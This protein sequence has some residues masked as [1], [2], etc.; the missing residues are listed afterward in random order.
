M[1]KAFTEMSDEGFRWIKNPPL[2]FIARIYF[3]P[4]TSSF[5]IKEP[6]PTREPNEPKK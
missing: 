4:T 2:T 5:L 6:L 3:D 1:V